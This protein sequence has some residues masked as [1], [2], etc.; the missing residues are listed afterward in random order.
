MPYLVAGPPAWLMSLAGRLPVPAL[1]HRLAIHKYDHLGLA[2]C[3]PPA[4]MSGMLAGLWHERAFAFLDRNIAM[5]LATLLVTRP[6]TSCS[7]PESAAMSSK[8]SRTN[9]A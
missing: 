6:G 3:L 4:Y 1:A 5:V 8:P 9:E 2:L 7:L